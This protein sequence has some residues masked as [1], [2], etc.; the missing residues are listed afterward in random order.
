MSEGRNDIEQ[1]DIL[2]K[3]FLLPAGRISGV[4]A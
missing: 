3:D 2:A 1:L 4:L